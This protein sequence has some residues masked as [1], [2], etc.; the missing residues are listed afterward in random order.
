MDKILTNFHTQLDAEVMRYS[1]GTAKTITKTETKH[2]IIK[3]REV[4]YR[5]YPHFHPYV[6]QLVQ[7]LLQKSV[8][9][10]QAA[11]TEYVKKSDGT[12]ETLPDGKFKP[13]LFAE[14][15]SSG[16]YAPSGIVQQPHPVKDLDFTSGG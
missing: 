1:V 16:Q 5:F 10:L 14:I 11:D 15:F 13:V 2:F 6:R 8:S 4:S 3:E 7:R 12:I 9:G